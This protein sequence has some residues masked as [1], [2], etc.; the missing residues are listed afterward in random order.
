M[1]RYIEELKR[2]YK[3]V[4]DIQL[5]THSLPSTFKCDEFIGEERHL[6]ESMIRMLTDTVECMEHRVE[7]HRKSALN[8]EDDW[9]E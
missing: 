9:A 4:V 7:Q 2:L 1:T 5:L 6:H 8:A 3:R